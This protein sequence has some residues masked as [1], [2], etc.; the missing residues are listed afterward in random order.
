MVC[1][2]FDLAHF[3]LDL[4]TVISSQIVKPLNPK[5]CKPIILHSSWNSFGLVTP[6]V[7]RSVV[8]AV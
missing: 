8:H 1:H 7:L 5:V 4:G 3:W 6:R 2:S